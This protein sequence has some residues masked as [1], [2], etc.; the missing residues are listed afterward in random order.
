MPLSIDMSINFYL[1]RLT[2]VLHTFVCDTHLLFQN[3]VENHAYYYD[4]ILIKYY[5]IPQHLG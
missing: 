1:Y 4:N 5:Y 3:S 2:F